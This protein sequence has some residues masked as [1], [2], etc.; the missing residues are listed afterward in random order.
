MEKLPAEQREVVGLI[1]YHGWK[2][3]QVAELFR[4]SERTVRRG[5]ESSL[6]QLN[7]GLQEPRA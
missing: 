7:Q 6:R 2:Q 3:A 5:W 4:V 1:F